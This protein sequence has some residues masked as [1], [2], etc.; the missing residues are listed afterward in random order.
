MLFVK[1]GDLQGTPQASV[2][3]SEP[4]SHPKDPQAGFFRLVLFR[5]RNASAGDHR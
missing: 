5:T 3:C 1:P 2:G 4:A